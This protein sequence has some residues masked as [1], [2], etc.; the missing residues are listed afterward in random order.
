MSRLKKVKVALTMGD[1]AGVGPEIIA[2]ALRSPVLRDFTDITVIGDKW[3][4]ERARRAIRNTQYAIRQVEFIDLNNVPHKNYKLGKISAECGEASI[5]YIGKANELIKEGYLDC[6]VTCPI[7]KEAVKLSGFK[8]PGH[9]EY[10]ADMAGVRDFVMMLMNKHLK[11]SLATRHIPLKEVCR[12][13]D[14]DS[15]YRTIIITADSIRKLFG[16]KNPRIAVCGVNP[17]A[18]DGGVLGKEEDEVIAP[19]VT[20]ARRARNAVIGPLPCDSVFLSAVNGKYD[21]VIAMYHDQALI[22]LK[23]TDFD[24][25]VNITLGLPYVRTSVLHGTAFDIAGKNIANPNS[26]IEAIKVAV[27]CAQN[28]KAAGQRKV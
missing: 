16:I 20:R 24:T 17:H 19:A 8:F 2:K 7:S 13:L 25:G 6:L 14:S 18:S 26:L 4:F 1:P 22:P 9:T 23:T 10:L 28:L 11:V 27:V 15:I 5:Q 12:K 21:A 3:V